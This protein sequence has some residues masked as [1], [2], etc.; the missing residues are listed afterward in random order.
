MK[1]AGVMGKLGDKMMDFKTFK[2]TLQESKK[3]LNKRKGKAVVN[4]VV[5][6]ALFVGVVAVVTPL[7]KAQLQRGDVTE[8]EMVSVQKETADFVKLNTMAV[9]YANSTLADIYAFVQSGFAE[10]QREVLLAKQYGL[11]EYKNQLSPSNPLFLDLSENTSH[12]IS[13]LLSAIDNFLDQSTSTDEDMVKLNLYT[14]E[15]KEASNKEQQL[16]VSLL[17]YAGMTY[18]VLPNGQIKYSYLKVEQ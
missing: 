14:N 9:N 17:D 6:L 16:L 2:S 5:G 8:I 18:E 15:Y 7:V 4:G 1:V 10:E 11:T 13:L 12:K 3:S